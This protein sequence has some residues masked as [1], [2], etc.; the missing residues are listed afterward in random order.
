M[1]RL[2]EI[3][4][5]FEAALELERE[6]GVRSLPFDRALLTPPPAA[7]QSPASSATPVAE[8]V[9][10]PPPAFAETPATPV[11]EPPRD[12][13]PVHDFVFLHHRVL[14]PKGNGM[15][16]KIL[17]AMNRRAGE[18][19]IV[20]HPPAPPAKAYVVLGSLALRMFFPDAAGSPGQWIALPGGAEGLVTYS[21][22]YILRFQDGSPAQVD[23]KRRMWNSL[24]GVME[25]FPR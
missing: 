2:D 14:S 18:A 16:A 20:I 8:P 1:N 19:P 15:M 3:L 12:G 22:E 24:K 17:V 10:T 7:A 5:G 11:A 23:V 21:P 9:K 13:G 25:R 6:L 4:E